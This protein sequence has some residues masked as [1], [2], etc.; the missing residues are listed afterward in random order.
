MP[1]VG[2]EENG[3][4]TR[5]PSRGPK[6]NR[7]S[8]R[9]CFVLGNGA[10]QLKYVKLQVTNGQPPQ[11]GAVLWFKGTKGDAGS[12]IRGCGWV[13]RGVMPSIDPK[14]RFCCR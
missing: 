2:F 8:L 4:V 7:E 10:Q 9:E 3:R 11:V 13:N 6:V 12:T 1:G 5:D 14:P